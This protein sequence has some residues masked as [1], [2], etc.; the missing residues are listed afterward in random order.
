[1]RASL[2]TQHESTN[3]R[4]TAGAQSSRRQ[5]RRNENLYRS[6]SLWNPPVSGIEYQ[7]GARFSKWAN[8]HECALPTNPP[9]SGL[10]SSE[11]R[12]GHALKLW[13]TV[14]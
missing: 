4:W 5:D 6:D 9:A 14:P 7:I 2:G 3:D 11:M 10:L 12:S 1:M 8:S 13:G